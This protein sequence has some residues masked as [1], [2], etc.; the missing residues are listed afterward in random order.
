VI[1]ECPQC[2]YQPLEYDD[3]HH[4]EDI[5]ANMSSSDEE[6]IETARVIWA[7]KAKTQSDER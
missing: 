7:A 6:T 2:G 5:V 3:T 1:D 4:Q